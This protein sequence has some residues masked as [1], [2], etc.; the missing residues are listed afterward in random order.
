MIPIERTHEYRGRYHVL[1]GAL[2]PIDGVEPEDLKIAELYERV[3]ERRPRGR[4]RH[5]PDHHRRGDRAP[6]RRR[7][8]RARARRRG[9]AARVRPAGRRRPRV[10]RRG[11]AR[12]GARRPPARSSI[13]RICQRQ[14]ENRR[15]DVM[16]RSADADLTAMAAV[17][18]RAPRVVR[19]WP[20][21]C[22]A[23]S[24]TPDARWRQTS[25]AVARRTLRPAPRRRRT[26]LDGRAASRA[27]RTRRPREPHAASVAA[28]NRRR[29]TITRTVVA[30]RRPARR[31]SHDHADVRARSASVQRRRARRISR[32]R[33]P[34]P[35]RHEPHDRH[36]RRQRLSR[37][38]AAHP[39]GVHD[40]RRRAPRSVDRDVR[41]ARTC[42]AASRLPAIAR[43]TA[44]RPAR[45]VER[46]L[47][48]R[49]PPPNHARRLPRGDVDE[50]R[51][52]LAGLAA[53]C[54]SRIGQDA[55]A[56]RSTID[57]PRPRAR[58]RPTSAR[59]APAE[60]A[61]RLRACGAEDVQPRRGRPGPMHVGRGAT[62][63]GSG[64][65]ALIAAADRRCRA[66]RS[67]RSSMPIP[68]IDGH[69]GAD[70]QHG[71][72]TS[73]RPECA[74]LRPPCPGPWS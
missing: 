54:A 37:R 61:R 74:R 30:R 51:G 15:S 32:R 40:D 64:T 63:A 72:R 14:L 50:R 60:S 55:R 46:R 65:L 2:S 71:A 6:H 67:A 22:A 53:I 12:Q 33:R 57:A 62:V 21:A 73:A 19:R 45:P 23:A 4:A 48:T 13:S 1:G 29:A 5:Q 66:S 52:R 58:A 16:G 44:T 35:D 49:P 41:T 10:R 34:R 3:D 20:P 9:H 36:R 17:A 43:A 39:T 59:A 18:T 47:E 31:A 11:H 56:G 70:H 42:D 7:A 68:A 27:H 69:R 24:S 26:S 38:P 8:A 25:R 28:P